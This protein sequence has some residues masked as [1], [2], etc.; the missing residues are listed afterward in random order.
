MA[1]FQ[2]IGSWSCK[3][4]SVTSANEFVLKNPPRLVLQ[5]PSGAKRYTDDKTFYLTLQALNM[6]QKITFKSLI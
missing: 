2:L 4:P 1:D 3:K 5:H 6:V